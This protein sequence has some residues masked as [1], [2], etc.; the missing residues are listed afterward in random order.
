[1]S[2]DEQRPTPWAFAAD[3]AAA[4]RGVRQVPVDGL[5]HRAV[6]PE[7]LIRAVR[8]NSQPPT[9]TLNIWIDDV[10]AHDARAIERENVQVY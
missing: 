9:Y 1:V 3:D 8:Q 4:F 10:G 5:D 2:L 6:P 7:R